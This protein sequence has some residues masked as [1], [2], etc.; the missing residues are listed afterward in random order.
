[1]INDTAGRRDELK[2]LKIYV[3]GIV[4]G[5]GFRP[6][7]YQLAHTCRLSGTVRNT[8]EGVEIDVQGIPAE[9]GRFVT[10]LKNEHPPLAKIIDFRTEE[11]PAG[12]FDGFSILHSDSADISS[13]GISPDICI[14]DDCLRELF[15]PADRRSGYPFIN[16]TNCGPRYTII[17][18]IPYD[19]PFTS[20]RSF[21]MCKACAEEYHEPSNRRFH[22]Q[23]NACPE[24]G[25]HVSLIDNSGAEIA[26]KDTA[27]PECI[28]LLTDGAVIAVKGLGGFHLMCSAYDDDAVLKLRERKR[29]EEKPFA[30]MA[31][32]METVDTFASRTGGE[33]R[34]LLSAQRPIVLLKKKAGGPLAPNIAPGNREYGVMLPYTPL[35]YL[36]LS[37]E[38]KVVVATSGNLSEEP[39]VIDNDEAVGKLGETAD[40][41]L[42]HNRDILVRND[43]SVVR[44]IGNRLTMIR[45]ARGYVPEAIVLPESFGGVLGCGGELK[46]S[47]CF[48][49]G[50][51]A[52]LSQHVGDLENITAYEYYNEIHRHLAGILDIHPEVMAHDMHPDYFTTKYAIEHSAGRNFAVQHHHAHM[53]AC[54]VENNLKKPVIGIILDGTGYG[55]DGR[56][57]GG[58]VLIGDWRSFERYSHLEYVPMPGGEKAIKEPWRM[59][60]SYLYH[61]YG[62][63][64]RELK[65]PV[66]KRTGLKKLEIL[67]TMIKKGVN[68]PMTSSCGRLF[69]G[70]SSILDIKHENNFEGQAAMQLEQCL[71]DKEENSMYPVE[72]S[73]SEKPHPIDFKNIIKMA[74]QD[75]IDGADT[76]DISV[77]IHNSIAFLFAGSA[78]KAGR[79][80]GI[81]TIVLSGGCFQNARLFTQIQKLC[82]GEGFAVFG[83]S[84]IPPNDGGI[85]LGQAVV[86][87]VNL[88]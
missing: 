88:K 40:F 51:R 18:D 61:A 27:V 80:K 14:C 20:M 57:W 42:V 16:C 36:L 30:V 7:V 46:N 25:P 26:G 31:A 69:D 77:K 37:G 22:A 13:T 49:K 38:L 76:A 45:R 56:I 50:N 1:M 67:L 6:F 65:I 79:E 53:A 86:A 41:F 48:I 60:V 84:I 64:I 15:D 28:R 78:M 8:S 54:M 34:L 55:T 43:D 62:D 75:M 87:A 59:A 68:S 70:L 72:S 11:Y 83:H 3:N 35:H 5:V 44:N 39:I 21:P 32:C 82:E 71:P 2:R 52:Y 73:G 19:R 74:A 63:S 4:Q 81:D 29:R 12:E 24:C 47:L 58:E 9:L 23:P 66:L 17:D 85:S 10:D 33:S